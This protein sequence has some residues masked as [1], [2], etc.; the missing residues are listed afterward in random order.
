MGRPSSLFVLPAAAD[1]DVDVDVVCLLIVVVLVSSFLFARRSRA[2]AIMT[3]ASCLLIWLVWL[4]MGCLSRLALIVLAEGARNVT[5]VRLLMLP[6][7]C[8]HFTR[9]KT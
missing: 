8:M 7:L 2:V 9:S 5:T 3:V 4:G 6:S 1:V